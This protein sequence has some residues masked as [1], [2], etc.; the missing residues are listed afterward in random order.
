MMHVS[1]TKSFY[2]RITRMLNEFI[3]VTTESVRK[4]S[5]SGFMVWTNIRISCRKI[6]FSKIPLF[7]F[8]NFH[9]LLKFH[10][11]M[12][13]EVRTKLMRQ[14]LLVSKKYRIIE[15]DCRQFIDLDMIVGTEPK[16][17]ISKYQIIQDSNY[18]KFKT[19]ILNDL[20]THTKKIDS[21]LY[22]DLKILNFF[23]RPG[24]TRRLSKISLN[25]QKSQVT[26]IWKKPEMRIRTTKIKNCVVT[27]SYTI[28]LRKF[29]LYYYIHMQTFKKSNF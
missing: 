19:V 11:Y 18:Y 6:T 15:I 26:K 7:N 23:I 1:P 14:V 16:V 27:R 12:H 13:D 24:K 29:M 5:K 2:L 22:S 3:H 25:R 20:I 8:M 10:F 28:R 21:V 17:V 4:K 9:N